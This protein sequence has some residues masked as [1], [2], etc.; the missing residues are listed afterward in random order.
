MKTKIQALLFDGFD[1]LDLFGAFE[2]LRMGGFPVEL[3]SLYEQDVLTAAHGLKIIPDSIFS[4]DRKPN[5]LLVPGGGWLT[6]SAKG[7]WA[8]AEKGTILQVVKDCHSSGVILAS[9]CTGSLLLGQAGLLKDRP[10]TTNHGAVRELIAYGAHYID[11]RVVDD[12]DIITASGITASLDLGIWLVERFASQQAALE[13]SARLE[14]ERRGQ[15][16]CQQ[17]KTPPR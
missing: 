8:E 7:A 1:E 5:L 12:G 17:T 11:V 2:G 15:V 14:F 3:C 10:A 9:V 13:V 16:I 6:R 4:L